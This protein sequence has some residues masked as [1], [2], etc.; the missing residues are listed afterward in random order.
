M[1][2]E[3]ILVGP[4]LE[5]ILELLEGEQKELLVEI[6]HTDTAEFRGGL[7]NRLEMVE[8]LIHRR[9][10]NQLLRTSAEFRD[11]DLAHLLAGNAVAKVLS[12][13]GGGEL[14]LA[15]AIRVGVPLQFLLNEFRKIPTLQR[16]REAL[17]VRRLSDPPRIEDLQ[18]LALS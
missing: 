17:I 4:E 6:R 12:K 14:A 7:K 5:L 2:Q 18:Q 10:L 9:D 15:G 16:G 11:S 13:H 1:A 3:L 8:S